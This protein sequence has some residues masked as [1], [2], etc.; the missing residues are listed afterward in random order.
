M[1]ESLLFL[2]C[3]AALRMFWLHLQLKQS[4]LLRRSGFGLLSI[5]LRHRT[6]VV[7]LSDDLQEF[8]LPREYRTLAVRL[9]G[10]PLWRRESLVGLPQHVDVRIDQIGAEEFDQLFDDAYR[11]GAPAIGVWPAFM[12]RRSHAWLLASWAPLTRRMRGQH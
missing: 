3:A 12:S 9:A 11:L 10:L 1:L 7:R 6:A 5:E 4:L 2:G 8:P